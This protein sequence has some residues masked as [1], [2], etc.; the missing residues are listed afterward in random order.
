MPT[1]IARTTRIGENLR[2][3]KYEGSSL[4]GRISSLTI[5]H[6]L[7]PRSSPRI[8]SSLLG[9]TGAV[10]G[11]EIL[12]RSPSS[13]SRRG[14][15]KAGGSRD[16]PPARDSVGAQALRVIAQAPPTSVVQ[17]ISPQRLPG[18]LSYWTLVQG[19]HDKL[20]V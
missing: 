20:N 8:S 10:H 9:D 5:K 17:R 4:S 12:V 18:G 3:G 1:G 2:A 15:R 14:D 6:L 19:S 7:T 16:D 13:G 11:P